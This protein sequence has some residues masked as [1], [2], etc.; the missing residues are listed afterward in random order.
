M[1]IR[2]NVGLAQYNWFRTGGAARY[3]C[4]PE[5]E[6]DFQEAIRFAGD[7]DLQIFVL[8]EGANILVSD[9]GF[10]GLVI[11]PMNRNIEILAMDESNNEVRLRAGAGVVMQDLIDYCLEHEIT[12]L[13]EFSGIPSTVGGAVYINLHY[14]DYLLSDF[15]R[16]GRVISADTADIKEVEPDWFQ[17]GYDQSRLHQ[18]DYYLLD[19]EFL[20]R[21]AT[22]I[23]AAYSTGRR[24]EIIRHRDRRYPNSNTCGSFF[25]NFHPEEVNLQLSGKDM[26]YVAY[27]LDNLGV[28]GRLKHGK[29]GVSSKHANM[30]VA[31]DGAK[32]EDVLKV[33]R[34]MQRRVNETYNIT[35]QPE[36]Q[37]I[38]FQQYPLL[39]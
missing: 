38:G 39:K 25:R 34:E 10:D 31:E 11:H 1:N 16:V 18:H 37:L 21:K 5:S 20:L 9:D 13:E 8:G 6:E 32:T 33:V 30:I 3:F 22:P 15:F 27:Y 19:A 29:A 4:E 23:E 17:F 26:I 28:K 12:G 2:E 36:C 35:P 14:F 7:K 24:D